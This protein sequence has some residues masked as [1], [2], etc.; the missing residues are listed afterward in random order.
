MHDEIST[1]YAS[2]TKGR[3]RDHP[4]SKFLG[5]LTPGVSKKTVKKLKNNQEETKSP[6]TFKYH[7]RIFHGFW[8]YQLKL[9]HK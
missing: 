1:R 6:Q 2:Y 3:N 9:N 4:A 5:V 7:L 8:H